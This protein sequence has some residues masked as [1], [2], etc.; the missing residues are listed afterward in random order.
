MP[1]PY[2]LPMR[3]LE[4]FP[5]FP[6]TGTDDAAKIAI[7]DRMLSALIEKIAVGMP[8]HDIVAAVALVQELLRLELKPDETK[9][10]D[11]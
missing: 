11:T 7:A 8:P 10:D 2:E 5:P 4:G 3:W 6:D 1:S 9:R